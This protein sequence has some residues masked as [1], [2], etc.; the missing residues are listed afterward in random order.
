MSNE[1]CTIR[2]RW[3]DISASPPSY[4][5]FSCKRFL[6]YLFTAGF[7]FF[8][9]SCATLPER[10]PVPEEAVEIAQIP[11][12]PVARWWGDKMPQV[13]VNALNNFSQPDYEIRFPEIINRSHHYLAI[14]GGSSEGAFGAGFLAGWTAS[15]Q[16]PKFTMVT[17]VSVGALIAPMAFLGPDYDAKL[18]EVFT[19]IS[20]Q[21]IL[22][23]R[24]WL[25]ILTG[26]SLYDSKPLQSLITKILD[27]NMAQAIIAEHKKGRRLL[28]GT[29]N[30]DANRPVIW[31][32]GNI[33]ISGHPKALELA[34]KILLASASIPGIFP[35]V[36]IEVQANG[37]TYDEIHIDGGAA[38]QVFVYPAEIKWKDIT[39]KFGVKGKPNVYV[40]RNSQIHPDWEAVEPNDL[41][42]IFDQSITSLIRT[43]GLGDLNTI[44]LLSQ[45]DHN[46]YHLTYIPTDFK[47]KPK[48]FFDTKYMQALFSLGYDLAKSGNSWKKAPP[49]FQSIEADRK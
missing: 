42:N 2:N 32:I 40:I 23:E 17:G 19:S 27:E 41:V 47:M 3:I 10:R 43:Q 21:D 29:T 30:L 39:K 38:S 8:L 13:F 33:L 16:R 1:D 48:E 45:R 31:N 9:Q 35:P 11:G 20:T 46:D 49:G 5:M 12:I 44:Y 7:L 36:Y 34:R 26:D 4:L 22:S 24:S 25:E 6:L 14:S 15:G 18:K 37:Q 28:I